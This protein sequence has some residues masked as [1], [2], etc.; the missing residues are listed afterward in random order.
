MKVNYLE[1]R[2]LQTILYKPKH[3]VRYQILITYTQ[4]NL[5]SRSAR[6]RDLVL[7]WFLGMFC[8]LPDRKLLSVEPKYPGFEFEYWYPH[9]HFDVLSS[10]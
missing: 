5:L 3:L 4:T 10:A 6:I 1:Q 7:T 2:G 8:G 9:P